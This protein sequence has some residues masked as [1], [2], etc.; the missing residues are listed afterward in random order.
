MYSA[1]LCMGQKYVL[2]Y[3][4]VWSIKQGIVTIVESSLHNSELE[5]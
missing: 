3:Y 5:T 2:C 1:N 4:H